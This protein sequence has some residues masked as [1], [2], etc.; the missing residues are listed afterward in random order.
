[1]KMVHLGIKL[2]RELKIGLNHKQ[3]K[4]QKKNDCDQN[5]QQTTDNSTTPKFNEKFQSMEK[6]KDFF[7]KKFQRE[8]TDPSM[9]QTRN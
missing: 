6:V 1:M 9:N 5:V 2:K 8:T 3:Q 7:L 4:H